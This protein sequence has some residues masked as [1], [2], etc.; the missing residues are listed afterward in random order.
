MLHTGGAYYV[1]GQAR[2][3][4]HRYLVYF[5]RY[6][7]TK[8]LL[9]THVEFA[10]LDT[11]ENLEELARAA[12]VAALVK[13]RT[14]GA[15]AG[16]KGKKKAYAEAAKLEAITATATAEVLSMGPLFARYDSMEAVQGAIEALE[17][18]PYEEPQVR[19]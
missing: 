9:P 7:L 11:F 14:G 12:A 8:P 13:A 16:P 4:L 6:L 1:R 10:I 15:K 5:Q 17:V 2:E 18:K 19:G 3:R